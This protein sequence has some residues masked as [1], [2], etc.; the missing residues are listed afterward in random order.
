MESLSRVASDTVP[1]ILIGNE[2]KERMTRNEWRN[3]RAR[4]RLGWR[5]FWYISLF[6]GLPFQNFILYSESALQNCPA[7]GKVIS[8]GTS[9]PTLPP[10]NKEDF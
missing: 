3:E 7:T 6:F 4:P 1:K 5:F 9:S 8:R 10:T 2:L